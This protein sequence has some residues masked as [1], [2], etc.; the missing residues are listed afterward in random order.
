M[1][2]I[3][4]KELNLPDFTPFGFYANLINP[5]TE[6][7]GQPPIEFF[8][9]M[10]CLSLGNNNVA[11]FSVCRVESRKKIIDSTEYHSSTGEGILPLDNDIIIHVGPAIRPD[12]LVPFDK[13]LAFKVPKGTMVV[14]RPG[15]LH[16]APFS[17]NDK[18]AN[19]LIV[20]PERAYANDKKLFKFDEKDIIEISE[21]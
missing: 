18:P 21:S 1:Q 4:V 3:N 12:D 5:N 8:R 17:V 20:L 16:H 15:V 9:E 2:T 19:V 10:L 13:I 14:L 11:S 7:F 6:K